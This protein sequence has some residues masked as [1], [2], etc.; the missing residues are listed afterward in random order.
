M[1]NWKPI[2]RLIVELLNF[3]ARP[4]LLI[5]RELSM[6]A[7]GVEAEAEVAALLAVVVVALLLLVMLARPTP[8]R[9]SFTQSASIARR[10]GTMN[11][12]VGYPR[13]LILLTRAM[14]VE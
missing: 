5:L 9:G 6:E 11:A 10:K 7:E 14:N 13:L 3:I 1:R 2:E 4:S 12:S 8:T